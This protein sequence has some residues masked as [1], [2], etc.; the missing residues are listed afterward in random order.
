LA[1]FDSASIQTKQQ[2][3]DKTSVAATDSGA[4]IPVDKRAMVIGTT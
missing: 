3:A 2:A 4:A 1:G